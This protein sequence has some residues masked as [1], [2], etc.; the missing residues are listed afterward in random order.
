MKRARPCPRL[1]R[2]FDAKNGKLTAPS[3]LRSATRKWWREVVLEWELEAHH[4]RL[5][6][7]AC[8]AWDRG[9]EARGVLKRKGAYFVDR[10]GQPKEHPG[11][12]IERD[13]RIAFARLLRELDLDTQPPPED[14]RPP[15]SR[16]HP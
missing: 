8:E 16:S 5:L 10:F 7:L 11:V 2:K 15:R 14:T 12:G 13:S 4:R 3:Y 9:Q 1:K 6:T